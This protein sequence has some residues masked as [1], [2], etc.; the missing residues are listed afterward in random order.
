MLFN[1]KVN[2][3]QPSFSN[4]TKDKMADFVIFFWFYHMICFI[5]GHDLIIIY[6][7]IQLWVTYLSLNLF[8][9][10]FCI[11]ILTSCNSTIFQ[12]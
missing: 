10:Y 8:D 12:E 11:W 1:N 3:L 5:D 4:G 2:V 9:E 7:I 6:Y